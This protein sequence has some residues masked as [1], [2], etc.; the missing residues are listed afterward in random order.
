MELTKWE[1]ANVQLLTCV[2]TLKTAKYRQIKRSITINNVIIPRNKLFSDT[3]INHCN[4]V[5][6]FKMQLLLFSKW[7]QY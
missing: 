6:D 3:T 2:N 1:S 7:L 4:F 5:I